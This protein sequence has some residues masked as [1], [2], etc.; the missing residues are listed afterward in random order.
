[1]FAKT[2]FTLAMLMLASSPA[3]A[4]PRY[5]GT[6]VVNTVT[7]ACGT[8]VKPGQVL[9]VKFKPAGVG[10]N[11]LHTSLDFFADA[12][13]IAFYLPN[14]K[15]LATAKTVEGTYVSYRPVS[16]TATLKATPAPNPTTTTDYVT[17]LGEV[18]N[19]IV[20]SCT[21]SFKAAV[22]RQPN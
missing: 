12:Q 3:L 7:A 6:A 5:I 19:Y 21:M 13:A 15:I 22:V 8:A 4:A 9:T 16:F 1:M 20:P 10:D 18:G 17:F 11:G 14:S 2:T